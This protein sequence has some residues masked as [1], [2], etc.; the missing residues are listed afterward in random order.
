MMDLVVRAPRLP[1]IG[2]SLLS[3]SFKT[4]PGGKGANQA[5]AAARLGASVALI[6]KVGADRFGEILRT[7]LDAAGVD[8][9]FVTTDPQIGTG[10]AVPIVLDSGE[11][12]ILAVPQSN[13][14]LSPADIEPAR[15]AIAGADMLMVQFEV[16]MEATLVAMRIAHEAGV[17][18]LLNPAP[19]A[20]YP[21]GMLELA[22]II[23]ANEVEAA[24]LAPAAAG[25]HRRELTELRRDASNAV[26]TLGEHGA[27]VDDG[28]TVSNVE[29]FNVESVDSVGAGDAFC[30][31]L[32]VALCEGKGILEA[33]R[34]AN[35]AGALAVTA[36]GAQSSLPV[37]SD[38]EALLARQ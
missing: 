21:D 31:G 20:A 10:V 35:A 24:A 1:R 38:V 22:S 5:I 18:I 23:V 4:S 34:F 3:H 30:A 17:P 28:T 9:T 16:G 32:A 15:Q 27:L 12:A 36:E 25:D 7:G 8:T 29:A 2:E 11:N 26:I 33:A 37:R 19:V 6:G 13:L 14:A